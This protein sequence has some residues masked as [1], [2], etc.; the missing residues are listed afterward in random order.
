MIPDAQHWDS[1][2]RALEDNGFPRACAVLLDNQHL[3]PEH[4]QAL[5]VACGR[6]GN[7]LLL[8][9]R[10]LDTSAWDYSSVAINK[11]RQFSELRKLNLNTEVRDV[12]TAPPD[13]EA[14]DVIVVSHFLERSLCN[15]LVGALKPG[16]LLFYQTFTVDRVTDNGPDN[17]EYR[18]TANELLALFAEL[19][20]ILY[21]EEGCIGDPHEGFRDR[22]QFIGY[23]VP[24][25]R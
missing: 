9:T 13:V 1:R 6:G 15:S 21:R 7:A 24:V 18:L 23:K 16:G 3:L 19:R 22:A 5:D 11:L 12:V 10:G 25:S 8:A 20:V 14:F 17:P 4:G 2:Y